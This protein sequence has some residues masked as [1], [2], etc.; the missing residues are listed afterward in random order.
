VQEGRLA[1]CDAVLGL[2]NMFANVCDLCMISISGQGIKHMTQGRLEL[3]GMISKR[4]FGC[5]M[6]LVLALPT[7]IFGVVVSSVFAG[8]W[9]RHA[10]AGIEFYH[11]SESR[12]AFHIAFDSTLISATGIAIC[13]CIFAVRCRPPRYPSHRDAAVFVLWSNLF[14]LIVAVLLSALSTIFL[15]LPGWDQIKGG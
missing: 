7:I 6:F 12:G 2:D 11:S 4:G 3:E 14:V 5:F 9:L 10:Y 13:A 15:E 8:F 1:G